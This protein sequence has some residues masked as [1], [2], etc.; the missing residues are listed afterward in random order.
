MIRNVGAGVLGLMMGLMLVWLIQQ[1]GHT[2]Y[3]PPVD[4][5]FGDPEAV[6]AYIAALPIGAILFV[7]AAWVLGA[8]VGV[9]VACRIGAANPVIYS[10]LIGGL[11]LAG[12][13]AMMIIIP[14]PSWF[15]VV[16]SLAIILAAYTAMR[17]G[18]RSN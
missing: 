10:V 12:A 8:F 11:V 4:V 7:G 17:L 18:P 6:R 16:S 15:A 9:F 1:I 14:H 5:D 3:P 2:V 13:I